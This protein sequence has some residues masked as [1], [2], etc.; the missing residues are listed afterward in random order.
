MT[1]CQ[2]ETAIVHYD[3][4]NALH[5]LDG[6]AVS[7]NKCKVTIYAKHGK[8]HNENGPAIITSQIKEW[9]V[10]G[11]RHRIDGPAIVA[12]TLEEWW[13]EGQLHRI[14]GPAI[15]SHR[16][17][18]WFVYGRLHRLDG[19]AFEEKVRGRFEAFEYRI[20]GKFYSE[21]EFNNHP[22]VIFYRL[23]KEYPEHL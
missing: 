16:T 17:K 1:W 22:L 20:D 9:Y 14:G 8:F 2:H 7:C 13:Y 4:R 3:E 10:E 19:P 5:A 11:K 23:S 18:Q 15:V 12:D 6:P 21:E